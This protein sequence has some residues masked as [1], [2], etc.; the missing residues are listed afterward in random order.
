MGQ[1]I[2]VCDMHFEFRL[3]DG[4]V[5]QALFLRRLARTNTLLQGHRA[6]LHLQLILPVNHMDSE[7]GTLVV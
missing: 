2:G 1:L 6:L 4:V 7:L 5:M 3:E